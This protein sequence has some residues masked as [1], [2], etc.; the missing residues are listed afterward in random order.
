MARLGGDPADERARVDAAFTEFAQA[1][2]GFAF[3]EPSPG[4]VDDERHVEGVRWRDAEGGLEEPL[5]RGAREEIT[6]THDVSHAVESVVADDGELV[7][8][9]AAAAEHEEI[10]DVG[11]D[12]ERL[13]TVVF[14]EKFD[15]SWLDA[16]AQ[17]GLVSSLACVLEARESAATR[18]RIAHLGLPGL[19]RTERA[20]IAARANAGVRVAVSFESARG[21]DEFGETLRLQSRR[22]VPF[23][24]EPLQIALRLVDVLGRCSFDVDVF[25]PQH[26]LATPAPREPVGE[27]ERQRVSHVQ[28]SRRA[29]RQTTHDGHVRH[30]E[31]AWPGLPR[32]GSRAR[33]LAIRTR[34]SPF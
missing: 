25:E 8:G 21:F 2:V 27:Q 14:I 26:Q 23:D 13:R 5:A 9:H 4:F 15:V 22:A 17:T 1:Q 10:T 33:R 7:G 30:H 6:A 29:R 20:Q 32:H 28:R 34:S 31:R 24:T 19:G 12:V 11:R 16:E 18:A 3:G